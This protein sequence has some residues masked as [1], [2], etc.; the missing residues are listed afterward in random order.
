MEGICCIVDPN[1]NSDALKAEVRDMARALSDGESLTVD[2]L[3]GEGWALAVAHWDSNSWTPLTFHLEDED[4]ALVGIAQLD[5]A[6]NGPSGHSITSADRFREAYRKHGM[7]DFSA[8]RGEFAI[9]GFDKKQ[10]HAWAAID[11]FGIRPLYGY[12]EGEKLVLASR[13]RCIRRTVRSLEIDP[14][15]VYAYVFQSVIPAPLSI[16]K[17]VFKLLPG[18][19]ITFDGASV[20][21]G[22]YWD[23]VAYPKLNHSLQNA[24]REIFVTLQEAVEASARDVAQ[25]AG[26]FLSGGTDSSTICGLFRRFR[27]QP[28]PAFSIGFPEEGYDE[29]YY[30]RIAAKH[31]DLDHREVYLQPD[32]VS[33]L[34]PDIIEAY[35]EPFG[36]SSAIP[37]LFCARNASQ[38]GVDY[39]L[40]GDG[41]DE[42]FAGNSRYGKDRIFQWYGKLPAPV[43]SHILEPLVLNRLERLPV[44]VFYKAGSYIR[45][46]RLSEVERLFSYTYFHEDQIFSADFPLAES[47]NGLW[48]IRR[49]HFERLNGVPILD[50]YLYL[51]MKLT[52]AD[53]DLRKVNRMCELA[54]VRV[55]YPMLSQSVVEFGFKLPAHWKLRGVSGLRYI[56]KKAFADF[57]PEAIIKKKKHGFGLPISQWLQRHPGI[58]SYVKPYLMP[59]H[60][61]KDHGFFRR[62][63]LD[64]IWRLQL[65][66]STP[67]WGSVVWRLFMFQAWYQHHYLEE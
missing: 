59:A 47:K 25:R 7:P 23:I 35:D 39:L 11:K 44:G 37:T 53:N 43:R 24:A 17:A 60:A 8:I 5:A 67:Y 36:N 1:R 63:F 22:T 58:Q 54:G 40:A 42:I 33:K 56:F 2:V 45:R 28:V 13:L 21:T 26:C 15:A 6:N 62:E 50:R 55:R 41:G 12:R 48:E 27:Q 65:E 52:I 10:R 9:A 3:V 64:E 16:Y 34:L 38:S 18:G 32:D 31:F 29:L 66:D 57:L 20:K 61:G 51:D 30:A 46:A 19:Y 14:Q 4:L 49:Q